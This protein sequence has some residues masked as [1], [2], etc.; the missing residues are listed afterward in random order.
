MILKFV[1]WP[2]HGTFYSQTTRYQDLIYENNLIQMLK[3]NQVVRNLKK[4]I[5]KDEQHELIGG[6]IIAMVT[7]AS[8][9]DHGQS[10]TESELQTINNSEGI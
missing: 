5:F 10:D 7:G 9:E 1:H 2:D 8:V 3:K 4:A 6:D